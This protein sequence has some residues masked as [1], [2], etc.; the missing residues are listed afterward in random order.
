MAVGPTI[1]PETIKSASELKV[2]ILDVR[3]IPSADPRRL[4]K[5]DAMITIAVEGLGN[6]VLRVPEEVLEDEEK[7]KKAIKEY[8]E[9]IRKHVGKELTITF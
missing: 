8:L 5:F 3:L 7:L 6:Y 2:R 4:G 9:R 1:N